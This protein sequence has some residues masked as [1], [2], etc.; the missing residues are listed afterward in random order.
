MTALAGPCTGVEGHL[1]LLRPKREIASAIFRRVWQERI[2]PSFFS[3]VKDTPEIVGQLW[4]RLQDPVQAW[5][6]ACVPL[7][8]RF[9]KKNANECRGSNKKDVREACGGIDNTPKTVGALCRLAGGIF[10]DW[11]YRSCNRRISIVQKFLLRFH[12]VNRS[13]N[14][15]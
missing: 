1:N 9:E 13:K 2:A 11:V 12:N 3:I 15:L 6:F 4:Q 14:R 5:K 7:R 8:A 10:F